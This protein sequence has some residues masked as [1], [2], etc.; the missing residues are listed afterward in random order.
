MIV[1]KITTDS[2]L[3]DSMEEMKKA[4]IRSYFD[5]ISILREHPDWLDELRKLILTEELINL[6]KKFD[7]FVK[8]YQNFIENEFKPLKQTVQKQGEDIAVLKEDVAVLKEDVAVLKQDVG[9]LKSDV[10]DLKGDSFERKV[11]ER[12]PSYFGK[13]IRKCK[14][15][16][17]IE[18]ANILDDA[19][20]T[21]IIGDDERDD[22]L[23]CD[24]VVTGALR[25]DKERKVLIVAEVSVVVDKQDVER[26]AS[27]TKVIEKCMGLPGI[28]VVIGKEHT[29]GALKRADELQVIV[30]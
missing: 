1:D 27:R 28:P 14:L 9:V 6:P 25:S 8:Q 21:G 19:L 20:D 10:G 30:I 12:A 17:H 15:I 4:K 22:A 5:L 18:L 3:T 16:S 11:R 23:L 26:A 29:E 2:Y 24:I 13:I 7:E